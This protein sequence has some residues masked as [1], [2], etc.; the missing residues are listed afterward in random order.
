ML[1]PRNGVDVELDSN[2]GGGFQKDRASLKR[3][4]GLYHRLYQHDTNMETPPPPPRLY[5]Y[6]IF[7][8]KPFDTCIS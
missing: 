3:G 2:R 4:G 8:D 5:L 7:T 1:I 6:V